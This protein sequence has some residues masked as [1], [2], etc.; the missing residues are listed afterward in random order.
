MNIQKLIPVCK[1]YLWGGRKLKET[2]GKSFPL[3]PCAESWEL[4][5]HPDG[6]TLLSDGS[7]LEAT[8]TS[9]DLGSNTQDFPFFPVLIK[10]ID[11]GS[12]LSV[13]VHPSDDYALTHE[14]SLGKTEMWYIVEADEGAGIYLGFDREVTQDEF[15][16]AIR[17]NTLTDLLRSEVC[18]VGPME[19]GEAAGHNG[20]AAGAV[21]H[22]QAVLPAEGDAVQIPGIE[23]VGRFAVRDG[24]Q[25]QLSL[26]RKGQTQLHCFMAS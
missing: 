8:A 20:V 16:N 2:Y 18:D 19:R 3:D 22:Q 4:S 11:A 14:N 24:F 5:F 1:D 6:R 23:P 15:L 7:T 9:A 13:Q 21:H 10:F 12:N 26:Q 25:F 17:S